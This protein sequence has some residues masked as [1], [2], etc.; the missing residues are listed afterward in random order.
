MDLL[1]LFFFV[2]FIL[3][4]LFNPKQNSVNHKFFLFFI[5]RVL[6]V[7]ECKQNSVNHTHTHT[8]M[9]PKK[10][11]KLTRPFMDL[12]IYLVYIWS[13]LSMLIWYIWILSFYFRTFFCNFIWMT[14][15]CIHLMSQL[16]CDTDENQCREWNKERGEN[17]QATYDDK[18]WV[19]V[20]FAETI[21][22]SV[23]HHYCKLQLIIR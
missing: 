13:A 14:V 9:A 21:F 12:K 11:I 22:C 19:A 1:F 17:G 7:N 10:K 6:C 20:S 5:L 8:Q 23:H 4:V 2:I 18:M 16:Y 3:I 15:P